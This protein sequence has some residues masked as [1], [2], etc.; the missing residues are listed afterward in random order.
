M[1]NDSEIVVDQ[2][3]AGD[4]DQYSYDLAVSRRL[5]EIKLPKKMT[6][7]EL[8]MRMTVAQAEEAA[9]ETS[10]RA[11]A[12]TYSYLRVYNVDETTV[13]NEPIR[14]EA[15]DEYLLWKKEH[16]LVKQ[17]LSKKEPTTKRSSVTGRSS[18][19]SL[20]GQSGPYAP[21]ASILAKGQRISIIKRQSMLVSK[22]GSMIQPA[23]TVDGDEQT[24]RKERSSSVLPATAGQKKGPAN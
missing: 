4:I 8:L 14:R 19:A 1:E 7:S 13:S 23:G 20:V 18:R 24:A 9:F 3:F 17:K 5:Q 16:Q 21:R 12:N 2:S 11:E 6:L 22:R 10:H 15:N